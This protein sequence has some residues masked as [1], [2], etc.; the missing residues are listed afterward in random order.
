MALYMVLED[1]AG[2]VGGP[3]GTQIVGASTLL[4]DAVYNVAQLLADGC[5]LVPFTP[6]MT[7]AKAAFDKM[8]GGV[9]Q[10]NPDG[11]LLA[12]LYAT[13]LMST[14][15]PPG[16]VIWVCTAATGGSDSTGQRGNQARPFATL[17][18]AIA[19]MQSGDVLMLGPGIHTSPSAPLPAALL[20][21]TITAIDGTAQTTAIVSPPASG[22]PCVDL[23]GGP[24]DLWRINGLR[25]EANVGTDAILADGAAAPKDTYFTNG[26]LVITD[27]TIN[28]GGLSARYVG[29][30]VLGR[31]TMTASGASEKLTSCN[32]VFHLGANYFGAGQSIQIVDDNDDPLAPNTGGTLQLGPKRFDSSCVFPNGTISLE[33]QASIFAAPGSI[34]PV[35]T[36]VPGLTIPV[37]NPAW[38]SSFALYGRITSFNSGVL[39]N[40]PFGIDLQGA[41]VADSITVEMTPGGFGTRFNGCG[42]TSEG[43]AFFGEGVTANLRDSSWQDGFLASV[44]TGG[45]NGSVIPPTFAMGPVQTAAPTVFTFPMRLAGDQY[46]V[47]V[48][49]DTL[50]NLPAA[51]TVRSNIGFEVTPTAVAANTFLR[52]IVSFYGNP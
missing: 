27:T 39:P 19:V 13:G 12:L 46:A 1:W 3:K 35:I 41:T 15:V 50:A 36:A 6:A 8:A 37:I 7:A 25:L 44:T 45:S 29:T 21:G 34:L 14:T 38:V 2:N 9:A 32:T 18:A 48:D 33:R 22:L 26:A 30:L 24:R 40:T 20:Q 4:D 52:A 5:P 49:G 16:N 51:V 23:S 47:A 43:A 11:N 31:F 10:I 28:E 42:M 17:D